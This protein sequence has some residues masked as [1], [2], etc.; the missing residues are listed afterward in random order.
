MRFIFIIAALALC[1]PGGFADIRSAIEAYNEAAASDDV[2]VKKDAALALGN[3]VMADPN[4]DNASLLLH[5][6]AWT[7]CRY[8][9][10]EKAKPVADFALTLPV[11]TDS[12]P[13]PKREVLA[14]FIGWRI[15]TTS[16]TR[17]ALD[18]A[19]EAS[20]NFPPSS[21]TVFAHSER[22]L[23]D[24]QEEKWSSAE[25][26]SQRA[27][28]H[29]SAAKDVIPDR[30]ANF[31]QTA[32]VAAFNRR[33]KVE[34]LYTQAEFEGQL[35]KLRS[36]NAKYSEELEEAYWQA[37]TWRSAMNAYFSSSPSGQKVS[38]TKLDEIIEKYNGYD[39]FPLPGDPVASE[40][41]PDLPL[42]NGAFDMDPQLK[43]PRKAARSGRVGAVTTRLSIVDGKV[44]DVEILGA[45][46]NVGFKEIAKQT[47]EQWSWIA[48]ED[49][50]M[51]TCGMNRTNIIL[52]LA[53]ALR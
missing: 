8:D 38:E 30:W 32:L 6:V 37:T 22:V 23:F 20:R 24:V 1:A 43:Y 27:A 34:Q 46:P 4:T 19:L 47:V 13:A 49:E 12:V 52:P 2:S 28:D 29:V 44:T 42:C 3:A 33:P 15:D 10:C 53:F 36:E 51:S 41:E 39:S 26:T 40:T 25:T 16:K 18:E 48:S 7:L 14:Q 45:V 11:R 9:D 5:E 21:L 17:S 50:T 31:E 35:R